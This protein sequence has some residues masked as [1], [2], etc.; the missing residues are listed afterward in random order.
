MDR[1][2][3][4]D[5]MDHMAFEL[6]HQFFSQSCRAAAVLR[7]ALSCRVAPLFPLPAIFCILFSGGEL[8]GLCHLYCHVFRILRG[9]QDSLQRA[10][11]AAVRGLKR[12]Q[13]EVKRMTFQLHDPLPGMP[14]TQQFDSLKIK[15]AMCRKPPATTI[16]SLSST[17]Q[18]V[19]AFELDICYI[20]L[21][22]AGRY[23]MIFRTFGEKRR[24]RNGEMFSR[25]E[26]DAELGSN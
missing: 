21:L 14:K 2:D 9:L 16:N 19:I 6:K 25:R 1:G 22:F 12:R 20:L 17:H 4:R 26:P 23:S 5:R 8:G 13:D 15:L 11:N 3:H 7:V 10:E 24:N 18:P